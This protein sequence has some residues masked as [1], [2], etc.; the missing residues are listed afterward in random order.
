MKPASRDWKPTII[1]GVPDGLIVFD[2]VCVLCSG[3]V[4]FVIE[5]DRAAQFRFT[6]IQSPLGSNLASQLGV[7]V[8]DPETNVA[9]FGGRAFFKSDAAIEVLSRLRRWRWVAA[10]RA[11]PRPIRDFAYDAVARRRYRLFGRSAV[12]LV[13]APELAGRF[14]HDEAAFPR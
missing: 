13:P 9:V 10:L 14:V 11:V 4:R 7:S 3:W 1:S 2:G 12:C 5:R 6:P 8:D